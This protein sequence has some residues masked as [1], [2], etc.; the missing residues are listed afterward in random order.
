ML[1][2]PIY[3][4]PQ[5]EP[6]LPLIN[7]VFLLLIFF[8]IAGNTQVPVDP[9]IEPPQKI[10]ADNSVLS[11]P[12]EWLYLNSDGSLMYQGRILWNEELS[13]FTDRDV[14]LFA[15]E[16]TPGVVIADVLNRF[17]SSGIKHVSIVSE[18]TI[19]THD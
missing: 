10:S 15:D 8:L 19:T 2:E 6:M 16:H 9:M 13:R 5:I 11:N 12:Y 4:R 7:I 3:T 17:T 14:T 1:T 18:R